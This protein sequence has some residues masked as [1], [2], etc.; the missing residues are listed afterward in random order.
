M[1]SL[2]ILILALALSAAPG[3]L[4]AQTT[5]KAEVDK[6]GITTDELLTY[7]LTLA[8][9]EKSIPDPKIPAFKGFAVVSQAQSS[10]VSFQKGGMQTIL[11]FVFI[12]MPKEKGN[13]R[14]EPA[15]VIVQGKTIASEA[16]QIEIKQGAARIEPRGK[17]QPEEEPGP[18]IPDSGQPKYSL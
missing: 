18:A 2:H 3:L 12:L 14:I 7:K 17:P 5:I 13:I 1:K 10:T 6:A 11:V 9:A 4:F 15:E 8:S 16:F